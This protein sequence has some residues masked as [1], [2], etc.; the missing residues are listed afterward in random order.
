MRSILS[1]LF[2]LLISCQIVSAQDYHYW[3][4]HFG[5]RASL[6]G[7][8]ATSG[9]G[10]N[11]TAYYNP[12]AMAFV[13]RPSMSVSVNAYRLRMLKIEN[14]LGEGMNFNETDFST[15]PNLIAGIMTFEKRPKIRLGYS[16]L[17]R[18]SFSQKFDFLQERDEEIL[19]QYAGEERVVQAYNLHHNLMEYW[20]GI[21]ASWQVSKSFSIGLAH[22]GVY[23]NVKYSLNS[24]ANILPKD[25]SGTEVY[26]FSTT[27]SFDYWNVKGLFKPSI[28]LSVE[29][30]K[31]GIAYT[32]ATFNMLGR[33]NAYREISYIN[34]ADLIEGIDYDIKIVDRVEGFKT[35]HK[36]FGSLAIGVSWRLGKKAWLHCTNETYFGGKKYYIFDVDES[37]S[38]YPDVLT[39]QQL[40]DGILGSQNFLS[41]A[42]ETEARTNIGMGLETPIA[43]RWDMYLGYRTDFLYNQIEANYADLDV[44]RIQSSR[45]S[46]MHASLGFVYMT[47]KEKRYTVGVEYGFSPLNIYAAANNIKTNSNSFKLLME[48]EVGKSKDQ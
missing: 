35:K 21:S 45:W 11:A 22:F 14:A 23:R 46:L 12:A 27:Q 5:A 8:A 41:L 32:T 9:L 10:D 19:P 33:G 17:T 44:I 47:K 37:P 39:E 48:I 15:M 36:E 38:M 28:A 1:L 24:S 42:E 20:A 4:E 30:F 2:T 34:L 40:E 25:I 29:N 18:R 26:E 13:E 7:G 3:S 6:L 16:V 43:K 31:L